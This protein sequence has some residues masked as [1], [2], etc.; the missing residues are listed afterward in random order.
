VAGLPGDRRL[1][2]T[3]RGGRK[4]CLRIAREMFGALSDPARVNAHRPKIESWQ[5]L[6]VLCAR[7]WKQS[8]AR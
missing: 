8:Y 6:T 3:R 2:V 1:I 7:I 4:P 5:T